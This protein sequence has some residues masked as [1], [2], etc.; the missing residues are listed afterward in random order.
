MP[1]QLECTS[2][3]LGSY[4]RGVGREVERVAFKPKRI[5]ASGWLKPPVPRVLVTTVVSSTDTH[6]A[7]RRQS[8]CTAT[9]K[10]R[11][12]SVALKPAGSEFGSCGHRR[13]CQRVK[14]KLSPRA[15][16]S[17]VG[18]RSRPP[19]LTTAASGPRTAVDRREGP[20]GPSPSMSYEKI[21]GEYVLP[22]TAG[23][24]RGGAARRAP[25]AN[26]KV[27]IARAL[28]VSAASR[29]NIHRKD[30]MFTV[31][32]M[33]GLG[34]DQKLT[35]FVVGGACSNAAVVSPALIALQRQL[36]TGRSRHIFAG[37]H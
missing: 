4:H 28:L 25:A 36:G 31:P 16:R 15:S 24:R 23:G 17:T 1:V 12:I 22:T 11:V 7:Q 27:T 13:M 10:L 33:A 34:P 32:R 18:L 35:C 2:T 3:R 14:S 19:A 29:Q 21:V 8:P 5:G 37:E 6:R 26:G 20:T 30:R 9:E